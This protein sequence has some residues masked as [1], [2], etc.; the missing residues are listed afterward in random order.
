MSNRPQSS[1]NTDYTVVTFDEIKQSLINRA[2]TIYPD[3]YRDFSRTSFGSLMFDMI[4]LVGEQLN[5]Y[6]QFV[7]NER[8]A[9]SSRLNSSLEGF[10]EEEG[11]S[12]YRS[13]VASGLLTITAPMLANATYTAA[14]PIAD[15]SLRPGTLFETD[16]KQTVELVTPLFFHADKVR[17]L[18]ESFSEDGSAASFM[19]GQAT[20]FAKLGDIKTTEIECGPLPRNHFTKIRI[21]DDHFSEAISCTTSEG[22]TFEEVPNLLMDLKQVEVI[23]PETGI[24]T[25]QDRIIP[26]R[27]Q[28]IRER[29]NYYLLFGY[30]SE[31]ALSI[32]G[33]FNSPSDAING[34]RNIRGGVFREA[35]DSVPRMFSESQTMGVAPQNTVLT[36]VYRS[37][38]PGRSNAAAGS[39]NNII[40]PIIDFKDP[41]SLT[42]EQMN[43]IR[44]NISVTNSTPFN[45]SVSHTSTREI[46]QIISAAKGS[47]A[48]AVTLTDVEAQIRLM[49]SHLGQV[50]K[51]NVVQDLEDLRRTIKIYVLS[52]DENGRMQ[53]TNDALKHNIRVHLN[54]VKMIND[55]YE[56]LD[57][58]ILNIGIDLDLKLDPSADKSSALASI[59]EILFEMMTNDQP[60][61]GENI[62]LGLIT[63]KLNKISVPKIENIKRIKITVKTGD[64]YSDTTYNIPT[65]TL[66]DG[67]EIYI[68]PSMVW[69]LK[70]PGDITG[71]IS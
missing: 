28:V 19:L 13:T 22:L 52:Q 5:F 58:Q 49:P 69:E 50:A 20:G 53:I 4:S 63:Q 14:N 21:P 40:S 47:Q 9:S 2:R 18:P 16:S 44:N 10:A 23:D 39:I 64:N 26:R 34:T 61:I 54:R 37:N 48:R 6:A 38:P 67:S 43:F 41:S 8:L 27:Y 36:I 70:S 45:G 11:I 24:I 66:H 29:G 25:Y 32:D 15:W 55:I 33:T 62:S 1:N 59:R 3:T 7:A 60:R 17:I 68:P 71:R 12:T 51:V 56:I 42:E 57:G 30:G 31:D 46:S 35:E 65:N